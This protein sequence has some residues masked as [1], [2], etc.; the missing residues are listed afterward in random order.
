MGREG[1][2]ADN[3]YQARQDP[4]VLTAVEFTEVHSS[5]HDHRTH[6]DRSAEG[7]RR[8]I[9]RHGA[10]QV[11]AVTLE[12]LVLLDADQGDGRAAQEVSC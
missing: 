5:L 11:V 6:L 10:V 2:V 12:D 7:G 1:E 3:A 9:D 4:A 8:Q